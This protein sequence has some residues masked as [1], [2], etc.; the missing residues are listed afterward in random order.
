MKVGTENRSRRQA[1]A[2]LADPARQMTVQDLMRH[3]S[4]LVYGARG[5]S[6]VYQSYRDAKIGDRRR[7]QRGVRRA[8]RQ[9]AAELQS[10]RPLGIQR[11]VD[12]QGRLLEVLAGKP[13]HEVL[14]ERIFQPLGMTDTSFQVPADKLARVAQPAP[15]TNGKT[16]TARFKVDDGAKYRIGRRRPDR[17]RPRTTSA[18]PRRSPMAARSTAS[19]SSAARRSSSWPPITPARGPAVRRA[20][21]S[22]WASRCAPRR[23]FGAARIGRRVWLV[24]RGGDDLLGRSRRSSSTPST[25]C[26]RTPTT[27]ATCACSSGHGPGRAA[28]LIRGRIQWRASMR[29]DICQRG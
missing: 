11:R 12:V 4:G 20:S 2:E 6:L 21:A 22:G 9:D 28:R 3:T 15:G 5:T 25:W 14:G 27:P 1:D 29:K 10:R 17:A 8:A 18:S 23:R 16:T 19:A 26:R 13:L 24:G 7:D